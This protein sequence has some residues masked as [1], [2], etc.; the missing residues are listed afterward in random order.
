MRHDLSLRADG[1]VSNQLLARSIGWLDL[2]AADRSLCLCCMVDL[3][4]EDDLFGIVLNLD[5]GAGDPLRSQSLSS[6]ERFSFAALLSESD[7]K[8]LKSKPLLGP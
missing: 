6:C 1:V 3:R 7:S 5:E 4:S 2:T 8:M